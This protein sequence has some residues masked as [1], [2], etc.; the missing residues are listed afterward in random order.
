[1]SAKLNTL[2][3]VFLVGAT[4]VGKS[5]MALELAE[6]WN[7]EIVS[8]D[9]MQVYRGM[10]IGTAKPTTAER[11]RVP[12]HL[13]DVVEVKQPFDVARF[14]QMALAAI[15]QIQQRHRLPLVVGGSGMYLRALTEG[16]FEGPGADVEIRAKLEAQTIETLFERLKSVDPVT[17]EKT[18]SNKRRLVRALEVYE[19]TGKSVSAQRKE[20]NRDERE[21]PALICLQRDR[22]ELYARIER[23]VDWMFA[24]G[25]V[26]ETKRLLVQGLAGNPTARAAA[27]YREVIE[28]LKGVRGVEE[29]R[30]LVKQRTRQLAKR[31]L[32][33]FR[34]QAT[35]RVVEVA[36]TVQQT[37]ERV[38][39]LVENARS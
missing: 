8:A 37:R 26:E 38:R 35:L 2:E 28:M 13:I 22:V 7:A 16:L 32:T 30:M 1:M 21:R 33:W 12:H 19:L 9:S 29:T 27:G 11:A 10:D 5:E 18:K 31:Q 39:A 34:H 36:E 6:E 17:A 3:P 14:R 15:N 23:R 24:N 4:A 25:L 20:W